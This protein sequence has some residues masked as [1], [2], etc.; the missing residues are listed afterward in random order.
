MN[1]DKVSYEK[2]RSNSRGF[3]TAVYIGGVVAASMMF[4]SFVLLAFPSDAYFT[5]A[6][7]TVAGVMV[8]GSMLAFPYALHNWSVTKEHRKW[9]TILY[10][11]EMVIIGVNTIVSFVSMLSKYA[12]YQS[13]EWVVMYEP[14]S[15]ASIIYTI[16]A[17]GTIFLLDPDHKLHAQEQDAE[18]RYNRK[19]AEK[20]EQ[21]IDSV[22]GEDMIEEIARADAMKR[23]APEN[24]NKGRKHFGSQS[25]P[26]PALADQLF[27]KKEADANLAS[28]REKDENG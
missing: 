6:I 5:R 18:A 13:P 1:E 14:F 22:E 9:T 25:T 7:M 28:F 21:F 3:A 10:Y 19:I 12:G 24:Y 8:G 11:I 26:K 17:W 15:V 2:N 16:F 27:V 20:R 4:I 23:F